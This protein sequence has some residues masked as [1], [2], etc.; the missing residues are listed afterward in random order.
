MRNVIGFILFVCC[1]LQVNSQVNPASGSFADYSETGYKM[2]M[3]MVAV[4]GDE[5]IMGCTD[6]Q[7]ADCNE[8]EKPT[9]RVIVSDFYIGKYEVTQ[10]QWKAVMGNNPSRFKGDNLPVEQVSWNDIQEFIGKLNKQT[11]KQY[12]LPTEAEWE[13]ACRGGVSSAHYKYSGSNTANEVAWIDA[14]SGQTT[15]PVGTKAPNEL[16][17]YD[18]SG[19]VLEWCSDWLNQYTVGAKLNPKGAASGTLR[20]GR[21]GSF[22]SIERVIRVSARSGNQPDGRAMNLGFRLVCSAE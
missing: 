8:S 19:N 3:A 16:G 17:I 6:E 13:F 9:R 2:N 7:A 14:N 18:M 20:V 12:R 5:F 15:H 21:G 11:G 1:Y 22:R 4:K 10:A